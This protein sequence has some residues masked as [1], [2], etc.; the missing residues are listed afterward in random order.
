MRQLW[1]TDVL[2]ELFEVYQEENAEQILQRLQRFAGGRVDL[3]RLRQKVRDILRL[4]R[5]FGE[6]A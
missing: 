5:L 3:Q 6:E 2:F 4:E 1:S